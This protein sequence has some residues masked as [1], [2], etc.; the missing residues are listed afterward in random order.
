[1]DVKRLRLNSTLQTA[2][3][4]LKLQLELHDG[5]AVR[6]NKSVEELTTLISK[7]LESDSEPVLSALVRTVSLMDDKQVVFFEVLGVDFTP[8]KEWIQRQQSGRKRS[9]LR[10]FSEENSVRA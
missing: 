6:A 7:A 5:H 9:R 4:V 3:Q 1:M 8:L 10:S 2:L